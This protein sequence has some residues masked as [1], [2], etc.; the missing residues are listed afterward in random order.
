M[1]LAVREAAV[2]LRE[3]KQRHEESLKNVD[4]RIRE[5]ERRERAFADRE[6]LVQT[7][8]AELKRLKDAFD[9]DRRVQE[10]RL[11]QRE[12]DLAR[13]E[14]ELDVPEGRPIGSGVR[15]ARA[16]RPDGG[17]R[18]ALGQAP[19]PCAPSPWSTPAR[20][21]ERSS[22]TDPSAT[23]TSAEIA[24]STPRASCRSTEMSA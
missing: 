5:L 6:R 23:N 11:Q 8:A 1:Q 9:A 18:A 13:R 22:S 4:P 2:Q 7:E 24:I 21:N 15:E 10:V 20:R 12:Q 3:Q 16:A 14:V 19:E 17:W